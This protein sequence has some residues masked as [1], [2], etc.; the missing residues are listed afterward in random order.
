MS[1]DAFKV[2]RRASDGLAWG[3]EQE[4]SQSWGPLVVSG[5]D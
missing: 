2:L 5:V 1:I 4:V 3:E